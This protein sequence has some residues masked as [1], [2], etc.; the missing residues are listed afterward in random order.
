MTIHERALLD[1]QG[2]MKYQEIATKY[3]VA[4]STVK[5]WKTRYNWEREKSTHT[6]SK[7]R[8]E[9][10]RRE[11]MAIQLI[12]ILHYKQGEKS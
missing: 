1:Y 12:N 3:K 11:N 9:I 2:G 4:L 8:D 10:V 5:S 7:V 6:N